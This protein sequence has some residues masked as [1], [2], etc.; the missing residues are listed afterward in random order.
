[1]LFIINRKQGNRRECREGI[2]RTTMK[3]Y[4]FN[5]V[6]ERIKTF[7]VSSAWYQVLIFREKSTAVWSWSS[8]WKLRK[9]YFR[10]AINIKV[11][12]IQPE[13]GTFDGV[14]LRRMNSI[15]SGKELSLCHK[16]EFS[17][18]QIFATQCR[19]P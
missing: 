4:A 18:P 19:G 7:F 12:L 8:T 10:G 1:M 17:N 14:E 5:V 3:R 9:H 6:F 15:K 16:L 13:V 2:T 11:D